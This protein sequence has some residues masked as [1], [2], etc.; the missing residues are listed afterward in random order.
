MLGLKRERFK[1]LLG[2]TH[3]PA[4]FWWDNNDGDKP[5]PIQTAWNARIGI[6]VLDRHGVIR[7]KNLAQR[8]VL[9]AAVTTLLK[10]QKDAL[11]KAR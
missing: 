6:Y 5:G 11:Q 7:C 9:E 4:R 1:A 10:E 8:D 3:L 2:A